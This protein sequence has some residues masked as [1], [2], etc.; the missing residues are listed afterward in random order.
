MSPKN[1]LRQS[2]VNVLEVHHMNLKVAKGCRLG[3]GTLLVL[4]PVVHSSSSSSFSSAVLLVP[5]S[6]KSALALR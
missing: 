2:L 4:L 3:S 6:V 1:Q 5:C